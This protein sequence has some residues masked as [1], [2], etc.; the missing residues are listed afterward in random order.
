MII[1]YFAALRD[2]LGCD[3]ETLDL[4]EAVTTVG[5]LK[6]LLQQREGVWSQALADE[7]TLLVAVNHNQADEQ[8]RISNNDEVAFFPPVTG[9]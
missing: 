7:N 5:Q 2:Q 8:T 6:T 1:K 4:P 9:G 3:E